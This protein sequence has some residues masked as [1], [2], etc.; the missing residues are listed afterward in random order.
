VYIMELEHA[1]NCSM[2][3]LHGI[4]ACCMFFSAGLKMDHANSHKLP[5]FIHQKSKVTLAGPKI[6]IHN[7]YY[8]EKS[9]NLHL[10]SDLC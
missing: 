8:R 3:L 1:I 4:V 2:V 6:D 10:H 9:E 5:S 7:F